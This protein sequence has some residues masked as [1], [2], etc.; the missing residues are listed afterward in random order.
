MPPG[1]RE[2][3]FLRLNENIFIKSTLDNF[4]HW[5]KSIDSTAKLINLQF[6]T[7]QKDARS[8]SKNK[9]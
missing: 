3:N 4:L 2:W 7:D 9:R 1:D 6:S 5:R 8:S